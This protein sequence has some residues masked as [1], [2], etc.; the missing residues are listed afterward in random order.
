MHLKSELFV[1]IKKI[2][3]LMYFYANI[4]NDILY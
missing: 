1:N 2:D 4:F 3:K